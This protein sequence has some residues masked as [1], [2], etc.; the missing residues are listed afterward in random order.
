LYNYSY[1]WLIFYFLYSY[2]T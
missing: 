2:F 1:Y